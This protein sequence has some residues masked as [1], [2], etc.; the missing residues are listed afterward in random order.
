MQETIEAN[1]AIAAG[2]GGKRK[3]PKGTAK[4][5]PPA[6]TTKPRRTKQT[7][8]YMYLGPNI[9]GGLLFTGTIC[10]EMPTHLDDLFKKIPEVKALFLECKAIPQAKKDL[11]V[12]G[13]EAH[14]LY[15]AIIARIKEGVLKNG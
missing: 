1:A 10:R 12:Q 5:N 13:S 7:N 9:P 11:A 15:H 3:A 14:R 8:A 4:N 6:K 2:N